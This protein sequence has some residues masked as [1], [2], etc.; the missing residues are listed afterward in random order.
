MADKRPNIVFMFSDQQRWDTLGCYGQ[1]LPVSPNLDRLAAEGTK[2]EYAFTCQPVCGP[3]RACLQ[4]GKY[5]TELDCFVNNMSLPPNHKTLAQYLNEAGYETACVG[6]WHLA[7]DSEHSFKYDPV[8]QDRRGGFQYWMAADVLEFTSHGY[9]GYV[10]DG[11]NKKHEFIGFRTDCIQDFAMDFI[12]QRK[13]DAPFY[14]YIPHLEPHH[15]NDYSYVDGPVGSKKRFKDFQ[16]PPDLVGTE[17]NWR[18]NYPDYLGACNALDANVGKLIDTLKDFGYWENTVIIYSSD[19]AT[20]FRTRNNEY[21][22][23]VHES[24]IRVP[25]II[26]GPGFTGGNVRDDLVSLI[27]LPATILDI[28]GI[29]K[30]ADF[31]GISLKKLVKNEVQ[32]PEAVFIQISENHIGRAIRTHK[33]AYSV[34]A[35]GNA[36]EQKGSDVYYDHFLYDLEN[37]YA[38]KNNLINKPEY[39]ETLIK[40]R[41]ILLEKMK[42]AHEDP[43]DIR[44]NTEAPAEWHNWDPMAKSVLCNV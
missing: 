31:Q 43:C 27:D 1:R 35:L 23:S 39:A 22:R 8:P 17:G 44:P 40:L 11:D 3:A 13:S 7:S 4:T 21:K 33:W 24:S 6:K 28:A 15:Q 18:E 2:F 14:L 20:H 30:P 32:A 42:E 16:V 10:Y 37:D 9:N 29:P 36:G 38:E 41:K 26:Y 12:R 34:R 25:M 5:A 19:H